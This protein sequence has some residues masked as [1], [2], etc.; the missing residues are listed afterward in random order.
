M[1]TSL[2]RLV[3]F[4][5]ALVTAPLFAA[6]LT[7]APGKDVMAKE[8]FPTT[9]F[10]ADVNLQTSAQSTFAKVIYMQFTVSGIPAGATGIAAELRL[11]SAT[12]GT[13]RAIAAHPV[14]ATTWTEGGL[15]W[16][17]KPA[18]GSTL[19]T[20]S[21]H[22]AGADSVWNVSAHVTGNGTY[23]LG[24]DTTYA[25]DTTFSSKEGTDAPELI[26]SYTPAAPA[27]VSLSATDFNAAEA[28]LDPATVQVVSST[29]APAGGL[30]VNFTVSGSAQ[31]NDN[32][33]GAPD[34]ILSPANGTATAGSVTI[35]AGAT[36][37]TITLTP[38]Q[39]TLFEGKETAIFTLAADAAYTVG[40]PRAAQVVIADNEASPF[41]NPDHASGQE[42]GWIV[43]ISGT[44]PNAECSGMVASRQYPGVHWYHRDGTQN[45]DPR[46]KLYA[47]E[48]SHGS[49]NGTVIKTVDVTAPAGWSGNWVNQQWEDMAEDPD[50]PGVFW[51]ADIGNNANPPTRTDIKL[52]KLN[53]PNPYGAATSV[54]VSQ[55]YYLRY[56]GGLAFN[57]EVL[58]I[59]EGIPHILVK[60]S[61]NPRLY[62]APSTTLSTNAGSPTV[63]ELVGQVLGGP[64]NQSL[65]SFSADRRRMVLSDHARMFVYVSQSAL[66][67][68][69]ATLTPAQA[70]AYIQDLLCTRLPA[71][72]LKHNGGQPDPEDKKGSV[73]GGGFVGD[74]YDVLFGAEGRQVVFLPAWWYQTQTP[75]IIAVPGTPVP[76]NAAPSTFLFRPQQ[77]SSFSKAGTS[78]I[79]MQA[80]ASDYDGTIANVKFYQKLNSAG[81]RTLIGTGTA[82]GGYHQLSWSISAVATGTYT[83]SADA[84]DNTGAVTTDSVTIT[85]T[86]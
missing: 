19:A 17:N 75:P 38:I 82:S 31:K 60:E 85:I 41:T 55:A 1:R 50:V 12:T 40:S 6:T 8:K 47:I 43:P 23:A 49:N 32:A 52:F 51:I 24:L 69:N 61:G 14:S 76:G 79:T 18:L 62:R 33:N 67:P 58:F 39:D 30:V 37:A 59:F 71:Y 53:E 29:P 84:T 34:Y 86:P 27:T 72:A 56:P 5:A 3:S 16:N 11:R 66:D 28:G 44:L 64:S 2:R 57:A 26:V 22:T 42:G 70:L 25:G 35:A 81:S 13:G 73:E 15:T 21:A 7:F 4:A 36:T 83:I 46:E 78:S 77:G 48:V 68:A 54:Q 20:V 9:N 65:G 80:A 45:P 74:S 63:M 10:G